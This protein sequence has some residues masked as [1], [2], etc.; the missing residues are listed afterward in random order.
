MISFVAF[1]FALRTVFADPLRFIQL[2]H[3]DS[4]NYVTVYSNPDS[5]RVDSVP[6]TH[7]SSFEVHTVPEN[8]NQWQL[9]AVKNNMYLT[10]ENG[11][12]S[13]CSA[14]RYDASGWETFN[15]T[16]TEDDF[17][18]LQSFNGQYLKVGDDLTLMATGFS[19]SDG[20]RFQ[21]IEVPQQ[22]AVNLGSWLIPEKW[23]FS[24]DSELWKGSNA[25]DMFTLCSNLGDDADSRLKKHRDTWIT[26]NDFNTMKK[27]GVNHIRIPVGYWDFVES[28]PYVFGGMKYIDL[29]VQWASM[30]G[31]TVLI[32]LHGAPGSQ[33]GQDHSGHAG[34]ITWAEPK[35]V[36]QTVNILGMIAERYSNI[37]NVWGIELLNEPHYSLTHEQLTRFYRSA[38]EEIRRYSSTTH[39]VINSLYGPHEW[40]AD[41][42]PEP[43]Y[44][45]TVLD[46]HLYTVWTG[47]ASIEDI[48]TICD[49]WG[50]QIRALSQYYPVI[51][52]EMSLASSLQG[53]T[54]DERQQQANH[55]M[56]SFQN[57][58]LGYIF[59]SDKLEYESCDWSLVDG[60]SYVEPYYMV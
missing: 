46:L 33:N 50:D 43:E 36:A 14:D 34:D 37:D 32:D 44:R 13:I 26:E 21:T 30:Y 54:S 2:R 6:Y 57:N 7:A 22:R 28:P 11:G 31:M 47:A 4:N 38:Y 35:N 56:T 27:N 53:Y 15:I 48:I 19:A 40:T 16:Y 9:R 8:E 29:A 12:N 23:M 10:A 58:A 20:A 1:L 3:K 42:F 39:V 52:G 5:V 25:T 60:Y 49:D 41:V 51:I 24:E 18:L 55:M 59:W 17:V 45:N